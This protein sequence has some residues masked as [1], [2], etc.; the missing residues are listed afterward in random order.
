MNEY[1]P[2][3][4]IVNTHGLKGTLKI[5][6]DSDFKNE[7]FVLGSKLF[8]HYKKEL[9]PVTVRKYQHKKGLEYIDFEEFMHINDCE[10]YKGSELLIRKKDRKELGADEYYYDELTG[11]SVVLDDKHGIVNDVREMPSG[12]LLE[13][14]V[15]DKKV[16]VPFNKEFIKKV[17]QKQRIIYINVWEGLF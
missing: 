1:I 17:D 7:R 15:D 9:V 5:K 10:K 6:S 11:M 8:I 2:V 14:I 4:I 13:I 3:G 16:L 12:A